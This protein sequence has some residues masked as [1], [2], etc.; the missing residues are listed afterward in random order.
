MAPVD[1]LDAREQRAAFQQELLAQNSGAVL[2]CIKANYPGPDK[3]TPHTSFTVHLLAREIEDS[4][5]VIG[6]WETDT[7]EGTAVYFISAGAAVPIKDAMMRLEN[8]H[9]LGRLID[10][11]VLSSRGAVSRRDMGYPERT[12]FICNEPARIC[13]RMRRH[14]VE[15]I[16]K[17]YRDTVEDWCARDATRSVLFALVAE[18]A[19]RPKFGLVTPFS[20]GRHRDMDYPLLVRSAFAIA[21]LIT[22]ATAMIDALRKPEDVFHDLRHAGV[23]IERK[24]LEVTGGVNT[25]RGAVFTFLLVLMAMRLDHAVPL[26]ERIRMLAAPVAEDFQAIEKKAAQ[27]TPLSHGEQVYMQYG[28]GGI[29]A[30]ALAG[31]PRVFNDYLPFFLVQEDEPNTALARTLLHIM[32]TCDDTTVLY[33]NGIDAL[34]EVQRGAADVLAG[35]KEMML[36][37]DE[38][39]RRGISAGGCADLLA[40]VVFLTVH[41]K[42]GHDAGTV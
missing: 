32:A 37:N 24:M 17:Y 28:E 8:N 3:H 7:C 22:E 23:G 34:R 11:D 13:A 40:L 39:I 9:P 36:F 35:K 30:L 4:I 16:Q 10:I 5:P 31:F 42:K 20:Q 38:C 26:S 1:I 27:G 18:A 21:P 6:R 12:C 15:T 14:P 41:G 29:R 25:H 19:C 33:R 2:V